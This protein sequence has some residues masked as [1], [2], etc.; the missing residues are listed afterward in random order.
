MN[1]AALDRRLRDG[2]L[3]LGAH[4]SRPDWDAVVRGSADAQPARRPRSRARLALIMA[5]AVLALGATFGSRDWITTQFDTFKAAPAVDMRG[6]VVVA[7]L[8]QHDGSVLEIAEK[9]LPPLTGESPAQ[10]SPAM[11]CVALRPPA[12]ADPVMAP[13]DPLSFGGSAFCSRL[14]AM[15]AESV[16]QNDGSASVLARRPDA[17]V[18]IELRV[19]GSSWRPSAADGPWALFT[20]GPGSIPS[21]AIGELVALDAAGRPLTTEPIDWR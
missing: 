13:L 17:A 16:W 14:D 9:T 6:A 11:R 19:G 5:A 15:A 8:R 10:A 1:D 7:R 3:A 21:R 18:S 12:P 20:V 4:S 2:V